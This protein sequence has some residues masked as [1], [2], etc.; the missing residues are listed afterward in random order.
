MMGG[1][2]I[3]V[4]PASLPVLCLGGTGVSA[5]PVKP[6]AENLTAEVEEDIEEQEGMMKITYIR[7][8]YRFRISPGSRE[9]VQYRQH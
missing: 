4:G 7:L 5:G 8:Y 3:L 6:P 1:T 2:G 9:K